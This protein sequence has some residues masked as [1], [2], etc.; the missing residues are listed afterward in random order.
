MDPM[1]APAAQH[2]SPPPAA[3]GRSRLSLIAEDMEK[4]IDGIMKTL[5]KPPEWAGGADLVPLKPSPPTRAP[6]VVSAAV[7]KA[8]CGRTKQDSCLRFGGSG[9]VEI[10]GS[11]SLEAS[12][13]S[14]QVDFWVKSD[15][16]DKM[17]VFDCRLDSAQYTCVLNNGTVSLLF[18][19]SVERG[20]CG[21]MAT[22]THTVDDGG[23]HF[24]Q[25]QW[26]PCFLLKIDGMPQQLALDQYTP[27]VAWSRNTRGNEVCVLGCSLPIPP[28]QQPLVNPFKGDLCEV[29]LRGNAQGKGVLLVARYA[30]DEGSGTVL[31]NAVQ[32]AAALDATVRNVGWVTGDAARLPKTVL[33]FTGM[34]YLT[35]GTLGLGEDLRTFKVSVWM[36]TRSEQMM[37]LFG[38]TDAQRR[39]QQLKFTLNGNEWGDPERGSHVF[40]LRDASGREMHASYVGMLCDGRWYHIEWA[41]DG[42]DLAMAVDGRPVDVQ[43]KRPATETP[44]E[45]VRFMDFLAIGAHNM[46][47]VLSESYTGLLHGASVEANGVGLAKWN[48]D[49]G[50]GGTLLADSSRNANHAVHRTV[51]GKPGELTRDASTTGW[52][53]AQRQSFAQ[54]VRAQTADSGY[55]QSPAHAAESSAQKVDVALL[56]RHAAVWY[57]L[58]GPEEAGSWVVLAAETRRRKSSVA[59]GVRGTGARGSISS[60]RASQSPR[61]RRATLVGAGAARLSTSAKIAIGVSRHLSSVESDISAGRDLVVNPIRRS[62]HSSVRLLLLRGG[63]HGA[64]HECLRSIADAQGTHATASAAVSW[65]AVSAAGKHFSTEPIPVLSACPK[66][67]NPTPPPVW[68]VLADLKTWETPIDGKCWADGV[69]DRLSSRVAA[70]LR[71]AEVRGDEADGKMTVKAADPDIV[72]PLYAMTGELLEDVAWGLWAG[73]EWEPVASAKALEEE[74]NN[75]GCLRRVPNTASREVQQK[76]GSASFQELLVKENEAAP[77]TVAC[78]PASPPAAITSPQPTPPPHSPG[79]VALSGG[80]GEW[81]P[82]APTEALPSAA[83]VSHINGLRYWSNSELNVHFVRYCNPHRTVDGYMQPESVVWIAAPPFHN[84]LLPIPPDVI[85]AVYA[86]PPEEPWTGLTA[87]GVAFEVTSATDSSI[88]SLLHAC[89]ECRNQNV[90]EPRAAEAFDAV[91]EEG[92][93]SL[94]L[95]A[96]TFAEF[97]AGQEPTPRTIISV[98]SVQRVAIGE[99]TYY[100]TLTGLPMLYD[101]GTCEAKRIWRVALPLP[102]QLPD[103]VNYAFCAQ[104]RGVREAALVVNVKDSEPLCFLSPDPEKWYAER[105]LMRAAAARVEQD[106][107]PARGNSLSVSFPEERALPVADPTA[108]PPAA[109]VRSANF[110]TDLISPATEDASPYPSAALTMEAAKFHSVCGDGSYAFYEH[111]AWTTVDVDR[112]ETIVPVA[113]A[114][115]ELGGWLLPQAE[116]FIDALTRAISRLGRPGGPGHRALVRDM[117]VPVPPVRLFKYA[118]DLDFQWNDFLVASAA[119]P[120]ASASTPNAV[121]FRSHGFRDIAFA[122]ARPRDVSWIMASRTY[123]TVKE[124]LWQGGMMVNEQ[125]SPFQAMDRKIRNV[126]AGLDLTQLPKMAGDDAARVPVELLAQLLKVA[127]KV[128][129]AGG[130][131][132]AAAQSEALTAALEEVIPTEKPLLALPVGRSIARDLRFLGSGDEPLNRAMRRAFATRKTLRAIDFLDTVVRLADCGAAKEMNGERLSLA[133]APFEDDFTALHVTALRNRA[134]Y[135]APLVDEFNL[136]INARDVND[137]T[138][139]H[140][141]VEAHSAAVLDELLVHGA[142]TDLQDREGRTALHVAVL[143]EYCGTSEEFD[144]FKRLADVSDAGIVDVHGLTAD[145]LAAERQLWNLAN[146]LRDQRADP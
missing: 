72:V 14:L 36:C 126:I 42:R 26:Q 97:L 81:A 98:L 25:A 89:R 34:S 23:F 66:F 62:L 13:D 50:P 15:S 119:E 146:Y 68:E 112:N 114:V 92:V 56:D 142:A 131:D 38:V 80:T 109:V 123:W 93:P 139:L 20:A 91:L 31:K 40:S 3:A 74:L 39:H 43:I 8:R 51:R 127:E 90:V 5:E 138:P 87:A 96:A 115:F 64:A 67:K 102:R 83:P 28:R 76:L 22:S 78:S 7:V 33:A 16:T 128:L 79:S 113:A 46:R 57:P 19:E 107:A 145:K 104:A 69:I 41:F 30:C 59:V 27:Q 73:D 61:S 88:L 82:G 108:P 70:K 11:A 84:A 95:D 48:F 135:V 121:V 52:S 53:L 49:D 118:K 24:V 35:A 137:K 37:T 18:E 143:R 99:G 9:Y 63:A 85:E 75:Y 100:L 29:R 45:F 32:R 58:P 110:E 120:A 134:G 2:P 77:S 122:S 141:A 111:G 136:D 44:H 10:P 101:C 86:R 116:R 106:A 144:L 60:R 117:Y 21:S 55:A 103:E 105:R 125:L 47:G 12:V 17:T 65:L 1:D 129:A 4:K 124:P 133:G 130:A 6:S 54:P 132:G 71:D 94:G 140:L